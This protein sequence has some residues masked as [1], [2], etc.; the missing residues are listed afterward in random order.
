MPENLKDVILIM[1]MTPCSVLFSAPKILL[2]SKS[3]SSK[4]IW[5][6]IESNCR[7][8][9]LLQNIGWHLLA[10]KESSKEIQSTLC[11]IAGEH[12]LIAE[13]KYENAKQWKVYPR[14]ASFPTTCV[15]EDNL[16][17]VLSFVKRGQCTEPKIKKG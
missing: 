12:V 15:F 11:P 6:T 2:F 9:A 10:D 14:D 17:S 1:N 3:N 13:W 5:E 8:R 4:L 16:S 7:L